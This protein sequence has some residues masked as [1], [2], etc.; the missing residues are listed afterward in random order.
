MVA[1][2][3]PLDSI[4]DAADRR[5]E[6][7]ILHRDPKAGGLAQGKT[8]R[9]TS[10]DLQIG[11]A[12]FDEFSLFGISNFVTHGEQAREADVFG[13][14]LNSMACFQ[15]RLARLDHDQESVGAF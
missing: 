15:G 3:L 12:P 5:E 2:L 8:L 7:G 13:Q 10:H 4:Q 6:T 1:S 11:H 9:Q 14:L